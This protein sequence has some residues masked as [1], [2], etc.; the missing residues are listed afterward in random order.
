MWEEIELVR[1]VDIESV[2]KIKTPAIQKLCRMEFFEFDNDCEGNVK[3]FLKNNN[4]PESF[5]LVTGEDDN[6]FP[7]VKAV[8]NYRDGAVHFF[9]AGKEWQNKYKSAME[10]TK[11]K[12]RSYTGVI[13]K[14]TL[15]K[16]V[17]GK[18]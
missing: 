4:M 1:M 11:I 17:E 14:A 13:K 3:S 7:E 8:C 15:D 18:E 2:G 12:M 6:G 9:R 10:V 16:F 5:Y